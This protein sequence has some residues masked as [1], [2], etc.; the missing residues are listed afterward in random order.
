[1]KK[2]VLLILTMV[3]ALGTAFAGPVDV[4]TAKSLGQKFVQAN[5]DQNG[6]ADLE[7]TYTVTS[8]RG[9]AC[10]YVF[11]VGDHGFVLVSASENVR[12]ILGYSEDGTFDAS[13][14]QNGAMFMLETY[15]NSISYA[16]EEKIAATPE[17]AAE[18]EC[19][20]TY[21]RLNN[22]KP[23]K[24]GPLVKTKWNQNSP[25]NLYSP[26]LPANA[27][28]QHVA[29]APSGRCYAGCVATAMGQLMKYWDH[30]IQG[31][32]SHGY[33]CIGYGPTYYNYGYQYANFGETTYQWDLM[34][35]SLN[36]QSTQEQIEA[37]ALLLYHCGVATD[38][39]F[40]WD[41]SG[42][43][44]DVVPGAMAS[45]FDYNYCS[46]KNRNSYN[47]ANWISMLKA[48]FDLGHPV[49]YSG[50]GEG[51]GHAFV[52]DGY[53]ENDFIHFNFGWSGTDDN[54]YA[55]DAIEYSS[56]AAAIFNFVPTY[57]YNATAQAPTS[58]NVTK[59][60]DVA[61]SAT[62]TWTNPTKTMNNQNI[63]AI[64]C[65]V[66][67]RDGIVVDSVGNATPGASMSYFDENV[68]CYSTFE[69]RVYAVVNGVNG[70]AG[71][72]TESFGP[73]C[74]WKAIVQAT[75]I[76]GWKGG[77]V[78]VYDGAGRE[79][80][81]FTMTSN[82]PQSINLDLT[83]GRVMFGWREGTAAV[84]LSI[85]LK[86]A[87]NEEVYNFSGNSA[88]L[89]AG[90]FYVGNNG[91]SGTTQCETPGELFTEM[92][93]GKITLSWGAV[94]N[95]G[96]G[97]NIYRDGYLFELAQTN[98]FV[99]EYAEL[100]GHCYQVCVLCDGGES[101][102][103]NEACGTSGEGCDTGSNLWYE[104]QTNGKPRITWDAP[105]NVEGVQGGFFVYRKIGR[106]GEYERVKL[107]N[108]SKTEYKET[109]TLE[110]GVWYYYKVVPYYQAID[111]FSA[112]IKNKYG[113]ECF[114]KLML[115]IDGVIENT[116][117]TVNL[118]PNP[119]KDSFTIE[120]EDIQHVMVYNTVGQM[121]YNQNC[122]GNSTVINLG[123]VETGIYM[124][125]VVTANGENIQKVS[126]IR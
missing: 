6:S 37:V 40:D 38:M 46:K 17:I 80:T 72:A 70:V 96:Y 81:S 87:Q 73:T 30:P 99:D 11:N 55:V 74:Q 95:M 119:T 126:V 52:A 93:D 92:V 58:V 12:P 104:F 90:Y 36:G 35:I 82:N 69:Y 18:W 2:T 31:T 123:N 115:D 51:G 103:S 34:P 7:L 60:S 23:G 116:V 117:G 110:E 109:K 4:N 62:I 85:K 89:P 29:Q 113:N 21:G 76:Q 121:V 25:Y 39:V 33:N 68:P 125:K 53:D 48:E 84:D 86:N 120:A 54:Y 41:G 26:A 49:Y 106:D 77:Y 3:L 66:I 32:G 24:V 67:T 100:G 9:D 5:F 22:R 57:V 44:S 98:T 65:I 10:V 13:N 8:D 16:I 28:P 91:C 101:E 20:R 102:M 43:Y 59:T 122:Q 19:L 42:T 61:Q 1:M 83:L 112:P 47:L 88:D 108:F 97:Y 15:K 64:D 63:S 78:H 79:I 111:C 14:P 27:N 107:L 71:V 118:F 105:E 75:A 56:S 45:Y 94:S 114:V 50:Q 124:V